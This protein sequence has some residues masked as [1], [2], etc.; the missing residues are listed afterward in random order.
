[1]FLA[2]LLLP[3]RLS[4]ANTFSRK[5]L[6]MSSA[7]SDFNALVYQYGNTAIGG[8][9]WIEY[10][11]EGVVDANNPI[12]D[13]HMARITLFKSD[14]YIPLNL[15]DFGIKYS[16]KDSSMGFLGQKFL[17]VDLS[18]MENR[19]QFDR[20]RI[21]YF[22]WEKVHLLDGSTVLRTNSPHHFIEEAYAFFGMKN[23]HNFEV[24]QALANTYKRNGFDTAKIL[25]IEQFDQYLANED[26]SKGEMHALEIPVAQQDQLRNIQR[27]SK[28]A[29]GL[30]PAGIAYD[31]AEF[32]NTI[33][34]N[35]EYNKQL[36]AVIN[37]PGTA[38]GALPWEEVMPSMEAVSTK[39][40]SSIAVSSLQ[41]NSTDLLSYYQAQLNQHGIEHTVKTNTNAPNLVFLD[42]SLSDRS[43][44]KFD[45]L[46]VASVSWQE[47]DLPGDD[48]K[49]WQ[50][51]SP[52]E[53]LEDMHDLSNKKFGGDP[54]SAH[55]AMAKVFERSGLKVDVVN[56]PALVLQISADQ[57]EQLVAAQKKAGKLL[58]IGQALDIMPLRKTDLDDVDLKKASHHDADKGKLKFANIKI[59]SNAALGSALGFVGA[60]PVSYEIY[61][62]FNAE[63]AEGN[64]PVGAAT[65]AAEI[66]ASEFSGTLVGGA[67]S[68]QALPLLGIPVVGEV[69][70][71]G[72]VLV[73]GY[74]GAKAT[75]DLIDY[76]QPHISKATDKVIDYAR[77]HI[78]KASDKI[79]AYVK[80]NAEKAGLDP[81]ALWD[82][83]TQIMDDTKQTRVNNTS[84]VYGQLDN[85]LLAL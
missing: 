49:L 8:L 4:I 51:M 73:S 6:Y 63:I 66:G 22:Q 55:L 57:T 79:E 46:R 52:G 17:D 32:A 78:T 9:P 45:A 39:Q 14:S 36:Y 59:P 82:T 5:N 61:Q 81:E 50:I 24:S 42:V 72:A 47:V 3:I 58:E 56:D 64:L 28:E 84:P 76:V 44:E 27:Y 33:Q 19:Q 13:K 68:V 74:L 69:A 23:E 1:M 65:I 30:N 7:D 29:L 16:V 71:G 70:Y 34:Y 35:S 48:K 75:Q 77:P 83:L 20:M 12:N 62:Q 80:E 11:L 31:S 10:G 2:P 85:E 40:M 60:I 18:D 54:F 43:F 21:A 38:I 26:F 15:D 25:T 37:G 53:L 67:A 41:L